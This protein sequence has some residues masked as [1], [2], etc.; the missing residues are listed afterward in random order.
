[1]AAASPLVRNATED[2]TVAAA[3]NVN[4]CANAFCNVSVNAVPSDIIIWFLAGASAAILLYL[5]VDYIRNR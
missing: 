3:S 5:L 1:M 4:Q 2:L